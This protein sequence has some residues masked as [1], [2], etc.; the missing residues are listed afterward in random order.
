MEPTGARVLNWVQ[1][2]GINE[3]NGVAFGER[4][5]PDGL[6]LSNSEK[7][8]PLSDES[9]GT[10]EQLSLLVRLAI[11]GILAADEPAV[12]I[13]DDPLAHAD[14]DKHRRILDIMRVAA[15]GNSSW[16]PPAGRLQMLIFTCHPERFEHLSGVHLI[17]LT[18]LIVRE[19]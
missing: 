2:L 6:L 18:K 13:L 17:D 8:H 9:Y 11:G 12:A 7:L 4:F 15:E 16:I 19:T 3:Y 1:S 14:A 10:G 5:L